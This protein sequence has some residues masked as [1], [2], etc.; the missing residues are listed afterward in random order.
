MDEGDGG[1]LGCGDGPAAAQ[2]I[3]LVVGVDSAAQMECQ[4]QVQQGGWRARSDGRAPIHQRLLPG[5]IGTVAGGAADRGILVGHLAIQDDLSGGVIADVFVSQERDQALLQGAE[6]AFD[7]AFGLWAGRDQ[8]GYTQGGK[9]AL[10]LRA[11]I[12][13]IGHGIMAK[14]AQAI[15]VND[16]R[17]AV[18]QQEPAKML[19][20]IPSCIGGDEDRA[21]KF[22]RMIIDG[23]QQGLLGG[24]GPPLVDGRIVLPQFAQAG[25]FPTAAGLEARFGL[26]DEVG[27]M[28]SDKGGDGL[29]M[30]FETEAGGQFIRHQLKVG[31]FLQRDKIFEELGGLRWPIWPVATTRELGAELGAVLQPA[32]A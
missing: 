2:E 25:A 6:A 24:G 32:S 23:Q 20:V 1:A 21:Q 15:S 8:V 26:A 13:I 31:R 30:A 3:D 7:L 9:G 11:G 10:E 19:E 5:R 4:M 16:Q 12:P 28:R 22:S 29:P 17:Q 27:E 18:L 14:E